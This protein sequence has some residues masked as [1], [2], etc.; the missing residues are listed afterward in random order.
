M[1]N[2]N[3]EEEIEV[4]EN[5]EILDVNGNTLLNGNNSKKKSSKNI[6]INIDSNSS[7]FSK[8]VLSLITI[9]SAF[10]VAGIMIFLIPLIILSLL[11]AF[12]TGK[13]FRFF[14]RIK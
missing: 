5:P 14:K 7:F 9:V 3:N 1:S 11:T 4:I 8:I 12:I 2:Q 13:I 6:Y 10:F